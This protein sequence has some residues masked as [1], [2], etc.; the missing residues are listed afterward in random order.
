MDNYEKQL[1]RE[2]TLETV[3]RLELLREE[4]KENGVAVGEYVKE[5][6]FKCLCLLGYAK[7]QL[8]IDPHSKETAEHIKAVMEKLFRP[9]GFVTPYQVVDYNDNTSPFH[10]IQLLTKTINRMKKDL[11]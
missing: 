1:E 2:R 6:N 5:D 4:I 8:G 9:L 11:G 10:M 7:R 3:A